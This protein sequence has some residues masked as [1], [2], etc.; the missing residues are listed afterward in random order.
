MGSDLT[1]SG[2]NGWL[3]GTSDPFRTRQW[4]VKEGHFRFRMWRE[5]EKSITSLQGSFLCAVDSGEDSNLLT[6]NQ[7][8]G[9][10]YQITLIASLSLGD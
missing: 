9:L 2:L 1:N 4:I 7:R 6:I 10:I 3:E 5:L 8:G